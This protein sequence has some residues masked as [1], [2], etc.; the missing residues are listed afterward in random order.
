MRTTDDTRNI[1]APRP[2]RSSGGP[3]LVAALAALALVGTVAL[4]VLTPGQGSPSAVPSPTPTTEANETVAGS[5]AS[6]AATAT[7]EAT[8]A[9]TAAAT[10]AADGGER[11]QSTLGY[12]VELPE[13]WRR[14][15]IQ[16]HDRPVP[17]GD[18]ESL[19]ADRFTSRS[20]EDERD[21]VRRSVDMTGPGP[22]LSY[23]AYVGIYRNSERQTT[24]EFADDHP[25]CFGQP[26]ESTE[27]IRMGDKQAVRVTCKW[28][29]QG[30]AFATYVEDDE[31]RMWAIGFYLGDGGPVPEGATREDLVRIVESFEADWLRD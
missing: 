21:A 29:D 5:T 26:V 11:F 20:P 10:S 12:T 15:E 4:V 14:S 17:N 6:P 3:L 27:E 7:A 9:P 25:P 31:G 18:P 16:S 13:G 24:R 19:A 2:R 8:A 23:T 1:N 22:A 28:L 30:T